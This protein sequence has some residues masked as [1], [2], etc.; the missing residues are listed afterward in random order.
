VW[1]HL[2]AGRRAGQA[3]GIDTILTLRRP[4]SLV[5]HCPA[6]P[7]VGVNIDE[8]TLASASP[9]DKYVRMTM[10][11]FTITLFPARQ[12]QIH[13]RPLAG[14]KLQSDTPADYQRRS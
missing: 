11:L 4:G 3:H 2:A 14:W 7:E 12:A 5:V 9:N 8:E 10:S 1:H 13:D 6:C